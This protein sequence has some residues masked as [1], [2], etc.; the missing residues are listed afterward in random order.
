MNEIAEG[1][2]K[3]KK[4]NNPECKASA[5]TLF[6][7][8]SHRVVASGN[9][10]NSSRSRGSTNVLRGR[11]KHKSRKRKVKKKRTRNESRGRN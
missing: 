3:K 1:E 8:W 5:H 4:K 2:K 6:D 9:C 10:S 7:V 11:W